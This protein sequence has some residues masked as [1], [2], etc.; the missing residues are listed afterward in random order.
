MPAS[1]TLPVPSQP[2]RS[3]TPRH[4]RG[5]L[6]LKGPIPWRWLELAAALPGRALAVAL[7]VWH[8]VGLRKC[9]TVKLTPSKTSSLG[10][11]ARAARR[12]LNAL[13]SA[14]LVTVDRHR[15]RSPDVT[16]LD[17][18]QSDASPSDA[19]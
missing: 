7:V 19:I 1:M 2:H 12:G 16:V 14:G 4:Q 17:A 10:L 5:E 18:P 8:L 15:G 3:R 9:R 11:S 6:F 13:E